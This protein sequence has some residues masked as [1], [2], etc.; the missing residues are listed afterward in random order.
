MQTTASQTVSS[1]AD[2]ARLPLADYAPVS[3]LALERTRIE[4]PRF[5]A[6]A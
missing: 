4:R 5:P 2:L 1:L 3:K 6:N